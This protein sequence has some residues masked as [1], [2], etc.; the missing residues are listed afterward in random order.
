MANLIDDEYFIRDI[1][2]PNLNKSDNLE[3]INSAIELYQEEVLK[4]VLGYSLYS[5]F[6]ADPES[7]QRFQ[8]IRDGKEFTFNFNGYEVTRKYN[9][10]ANE[11]LKSL[12]AYYVYFKY[13]GNRASHM[14]GVGNNMPSTENATRIDPNYKM[15]NAWNRFV[16][17]SGNP[18]MCEDSNRI[19]FYKKSCRFVKFDLS[20]YDF[21]DDSGSLFNFLLANKDVYPEWQFE[22][23]SKINVFGV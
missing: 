3:A 1:A 9:G 8:D 20:T 4:S 23:Q 13:V 7:E 19:H 10:L 18:L 12:I 2:L 16:S 22:P 6:I 11:E 5:L 21:K 17:L 14:G 15:V